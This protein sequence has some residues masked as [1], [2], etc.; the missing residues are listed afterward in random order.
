ME[1]F[2]STV[3][4]VNEHVH[5]EENP[6]FLKEQILTY[7][8]NKR[9]FLHLIGREVDRVRTRL[10]RERISCVDLFS[11]SGIVARY[12]KR[13]SSTLYVND[14]EPYSTCMSECYLANKSQVDER[15]LHETLGTLKKEIR[16]QWAPG[17]IAEMYAPQDDRHIQKGER[18]FYTRR[19]AVYLD[20][21]RRL[22][23]QLPG[24][25]QRFFLAP[26]LYS[27]SVHTNT[28]GVFKGFYKNR[29]GI[30]QFGGEGRNSLSRILG[31]IDLEMPVFSSFECEVHVLQRESRVAAQSLPEV[32]FCYMDPPYNEHPYGSNYFML[33]LILK[34]RRPAS[35]SPV[36][37][38]PEHWNRSA[39]NRPQQAREHFFSLIRECPAKF[40][41]IS[42]NSEG[43][44]PYGELADFLRSLG[45]VRS[46]ETDYNT[47]RGCRNLRKRPCTVKEYLF[48][49]ERR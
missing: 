17:W 16:L 13:F 14:L 28:S 19:N 44:I 45:R 25:L 20:T 10:G 7:L 12:L 8:G 9:S 3:G 30:G 4:N 49:L 22:I 48:L 46:Q 27:A 37:G 18:A 34:N 31:A 36:S 35:V 33:N 38:I 1:E 32:D 15:L 47:F 43:F 21:A 11:G 39:Y 41:L 23:A 24:D 2:L 42:Y 6:A 40:I 26:L 29:A 5:L